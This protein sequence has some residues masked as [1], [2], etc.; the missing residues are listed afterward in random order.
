MTLPE[1]IV[2]AAVILPLWAIAGHAGNARY[3]LER[4]A[5]CL[6]VEMEREDARRLA[7]AQTTEEI[8]RRAIAEEMRR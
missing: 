5:Y 8:R 4:I 2:A 3:A 7:D 6:G 1:I